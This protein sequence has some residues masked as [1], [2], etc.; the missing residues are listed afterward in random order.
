MLYLVVANM[1]RIILPPR[2]MANKELNIG[3]L[4]IFCEGS[5]EENYL[6]YFSNIINQSKYND[7]AVEINTADGNAMT[8]LKYANDFLS[9]EVNQRKYNNYE[10]YLIFD[11]DDPPNVQEVISMALSSENEYNL[12]ISNPLFEIWLL[13]H[14]EEVSSTLGKRTIYKKMEDHLNLDDKTY[15][16]HK[17][18]S[19]IIRQ[20]ISTESVKSAIDNA[21]TLEIF[22]NSQNK[23]FSTNLDELNPYTNL[24]TLVEQ[25]LVAVSKR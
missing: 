19:G 12:L 1:S 18:D 5:T 15:A 3:R 25:F 13:M 2:A 8:V 21:K 11:C 20:I 7:V 4:I 10:K 22:Y 17:N 9:K 23:T 16:K 6:K 14:F 24:H